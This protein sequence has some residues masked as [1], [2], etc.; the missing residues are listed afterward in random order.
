M[1]RVFVCKTGELAEGDARKVDCQ[2]AALAVFNSGGVLYATLDMCSHGNASM[3]EGYLE[4]DGTVECP[5][6]AARFCLKTGRALCLPATD[7]LRTFPVVEDGGAIYV[8]VPEES[9]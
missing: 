8:E 9:A 7:P 2:P 5:L 4:D 3:S 1:R 6:H